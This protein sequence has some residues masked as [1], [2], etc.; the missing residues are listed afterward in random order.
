MNPKEIVRRGYQEIA[1]EY[2]ER[3]ALRQEVWNRYLDRHRKFMPRRGRVLDLGCGGG[4][5]VSKYFQDHGY[6]VTGIDISPEMVDLARASVP[7]AEFKVMDMSDLEFED[8]SFDI[9]VSFY[10]IIH[11]PRDEHERT[12]SRLFRMP[13]PGGS[14][15]ISFGVEDREQTFESQLAWRGD[16]LVAF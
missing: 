10:T 11:V 8:H 14:I 7:T 9:I 6:Q 13:R 15:L 2:H 3:R 16:V 4:L 1:K 5:P 12:L